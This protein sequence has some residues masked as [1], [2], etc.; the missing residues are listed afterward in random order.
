MTDVKNQPKITFEENVIKILY[1]R[2]KGFVLPLVV[3]F[4]SIIIFFQLIVPQLQEW[5]SMRDQEDVMKGKIQVLKNN[6][7]FLSGMNDST[8]ESQYT[9]SSS[10]F[11]SEK[12]FIG[13][14][15][16]I[17][18]TS[19]NSGVRV[20]DF[21]FQVGEIAEKP[22]AQGNS[23]LSIKL[24]LNVG[25]DLAQTKK[26][27]EELSKTAPISGVE[28]VQTSGNAATVAI[29]FYYRPAASVMINYEQQIQ[30]LNPTE[31]ATLEKL[32]SWGSS[33]N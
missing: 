11:P 14:L 25:G 3:I 5:F 28:S 20:G 31:R 19:G 29:L 9:L 33:G 21:S 18:M 22:K 10:V 24:V 30:P 15:D 8:L 4:L 7:N 32:A 26:F 16:K 17:S 6:L 12:D 23:R 27:L 13:I 2:Y 1:F